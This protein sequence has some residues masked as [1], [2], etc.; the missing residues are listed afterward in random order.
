MKLTPKQR[1]WLKSYLDCSSK[2][3]FGNATASARAAGYKCKTSR[4]FESIGHENLRKLEDPIEKW[5]NESALSKSRLK[6]L[7]TDGLEA[8]ET[9][10]FAFRG[11]VID[12][13]EVIPWDI[14]RKYLELAFKVQDFDGILKRIEALEE[15]L[16]TL[17]EGGK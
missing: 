9:K 4:C 8:L 2:E 13:K 6:L 10:F 16:Q 11:M 15:S 7:L 1:L 17:K 5:I 12:E 3:T 14:R